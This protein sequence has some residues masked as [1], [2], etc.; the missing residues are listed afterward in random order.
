MLESD[1][2]WFKSQQGS[3]WAVGSWP[4]GLTPLRLQNGNNN[5]TQAID[6]WWQCSETVDPTQC[7]APSECS[8]QG[9][10]SIA[11]WILTSPSFSSFTQPHCWAS[12]SPTL[13]LLWVLIPGILVPWILQ[14]LA[15]FHLGGGVGRKMLL[16]HSACS[17][18]PVCTP[19]P[20]SR[21]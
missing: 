19:L 15:A 20:H 17:R 18:P 8:V 16:L 11:G 21:W 14:S 6:L 12:T 2:P 5:S 4:S 7:L 13:F 3:F 10:Y 1:R 9:H